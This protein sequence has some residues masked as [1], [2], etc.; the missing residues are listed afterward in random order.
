MKDSLKR[1]GRA[2][3]GRS[4]GRPIGIFSCKIIAKIKHRGQRF[5]AE[6]KIILVKGE[7]VRNGVCAGS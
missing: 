3:A 7:I 6:A 4:K 5:I 2:S 1:G